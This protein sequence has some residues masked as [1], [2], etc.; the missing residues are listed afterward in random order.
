MKLQD[1]V[2]KVQPFDLLLFHGTGIFSTA[3]RKMQALAMDTGEFSH[4]GIVINSEL[5]PD[6]PQLV[7]GRTYILDSNLVVPVVTDGVKDVRTNKVRFGVQIR[8]A[9]DVFTAFYDKSEDNY[10]SWCRLQE[11]P[12][13]NIEDKKEIKKDMLEFIEE[14]G[15]K[16]YELNCFELLGSLCGCFKNIRVKIEEE[17]VEGYRVLS[18]FGVT[19]ERSAEDIQRMSVFCSEFVGI[20][21]QIVHKIP[22]NVATSEIAPMHFINPREGTFVKFVDDPIRITLI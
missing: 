16:P 20:I 6:I 1:F 22:P 21:L 4:V 15:Y 10:I 7:S 18:L 13:L 9:L 14:F 19:E 5:F 17:V 11:N 8:D 3:I 12:W 2:D